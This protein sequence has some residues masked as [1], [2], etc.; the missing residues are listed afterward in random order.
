M[1]YLLKAANAGAIYALV[2]SCN[3]RVDLVKRHYRPG[4]Y[5][6][7]GSHNGG[8]DR[9]DRQ[10]PMAVAPDTLR[11]NGRAEGTTA[12]APASELRSFPFTYTKADMPG[13]SELVASI[14]SDKVKPSRMPTRPQFSWRPT[15]NVR[16][17]T[18]QQRAS[19]RRSASLEASV[20]EPEGLGAGYSVMRI[21]EGIGFGLLMVGLILSLVSIM[22]PELLVF[23]VATGV[24]GLVMF[25]VF[26]LIRIG[27]KRRHEQDPPTPPV[28][29]EPAPAVDQP[30]IDQFIEV[31]YLKNGSIIKGIIVEQVPG[32][33]LKIQTADGSLFVFKMDEVLKTTK[34]PIKK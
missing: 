11:S 26:A 24:I 10:G 31:V 5:V 15:V 33:S 13:R 18:T 14:N 12:A 7:G 20:T 4:W 28:E 32:E 27:M 34:E 25:I 19:D 8:V 29:R 9:V 30:T 17:G 23:G 16:V 22:V 21:F 3:V 2:L 1:R 6:A